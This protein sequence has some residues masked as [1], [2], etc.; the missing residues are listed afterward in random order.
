MSNVRIKFTSPYVV[1]A[2]DGATY[3]V[4]DTLDCSNEASAEHFCRRGVA[5]RVEA[6]PAPTPEAVPSA[7]K[8]AAKPSKG[9]APAAKK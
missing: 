4:G 2:A 7:P 1:K 9:R 5:V 3:E 6:A 8:P